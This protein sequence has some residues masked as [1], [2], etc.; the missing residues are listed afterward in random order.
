MPLPDNAH[1]LAIMDTAH[2]RAVERPTVFA[3][4]L[5][6]FFDTQRP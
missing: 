1:P 4:L 2:L 6:D 3:K 5:S